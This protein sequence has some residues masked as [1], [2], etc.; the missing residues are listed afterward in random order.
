MST[1]ASLTVA[2]TLFPFLYGPRAPLHTDNDF[3]KITDAGESSNLPLP[4]PLQLEASGK[5]ST[6]FS[7]V[8]GSSRSLECDQGTALLIPVQLS[9]ETQ[10]YGICED[11][12]DRALIDC[13]SL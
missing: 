10:L 7:R 1:D 8:D 5:K 11:P 12:R 4:S 3:E 2:R 13:W 6:H 9:M